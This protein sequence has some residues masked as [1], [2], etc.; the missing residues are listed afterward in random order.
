MHEKV[1]KLIVESPAFKDKGPIPTKYTCTGEDISPP[2][3]IKKVPAN[4][5]SYAII[6]EDPD[7]TRGTFDH[8]IAW[9]LPADQTILEEGVQVA[10]QGKNGAGINK[11]KGPCPP[12]GKPH[13]YFFRVYALD[14][15]L[16]LPE[17][18][19][20]QDLLKAM[21]THILAQG[22]LMGTFQ[23]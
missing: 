21:E 11:Y 19:T 2:L 9:N 12:P 17:G 1:E 22:E 4:A 23:K 20:K 18:S 3:S 16:H 6:V 7:A 5:K 8:W 10:W 14:Q 15:I 13:R